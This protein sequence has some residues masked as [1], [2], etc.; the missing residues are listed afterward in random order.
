[1]SKSVS[2]FVQLNSSS[3]RYTDSGGYETD[4]FGCRAGCECSTSTIIGDMK[5]DREES[6]NTKS[7]ERKFVPKR[8]KPWDDIF[9]DEK[10]QIPYKIDKKIANNHRFEV[11]L[12]TAFEKLESQTSLKF[13]EQTNEE[14]YLFFID[15]S[16]CHSSVGQQK[17]TGAQDIT[18]GP[19]C[20]Y[21]FTIIHEASFLV[22][23]SL[24]F[25]R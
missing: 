6:L 4:E 9:K 19:G 1:M 11:A 2:W 24:D 25:F 8:F 5:I 14:R 18:L 15:G 22:R 12:T 23:L 20:Y 7:G 17:K 10:Y 3:V 21:H 13:I 16:G